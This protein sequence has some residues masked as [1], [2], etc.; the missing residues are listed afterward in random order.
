M[1]VVKR[2]II[3][4]LICICFLKTYWSYQQQGF[5]SYSEQTP[6]KISFTCHSQCLLLL[7][8][9]LHNDTVFI[10]GVH[11]NG[12]LVIAV[13]DQKNQLIPITQQ[14]IDDRSSYNIL[15]KGPQIGE[16]PAQAPIVL[17]VVWQVVANDAY[18]VLER[19]SLGDKFIAGFREFWEIGAFM[20]YSINLTK[21]PTVLWTSMNYYF[22]WFIIIAFLSILFFKK[23][24][25]IVVISIFSLWILYSI[26]MDIEFLSYTYD[27]YITWIAESDMS[28]KSY[29][30]IYANFPVFVNWS[31]D[32]VSKKWMKSYHFYTQQVWPFTPFIKYNL[33]P[34]QLLDMNSDTLIVWNSVVN[35]QT[36][37][38]YY[39]NNTKKFIYST[40]VSFP[41]GGNSFIYFK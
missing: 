27:N 17:V 11:W 25:A 29:K 12:Q 36:W 38:V 32:E 33:Y 31:R 20:P 41:Y 3:L 30:K 6:D 39:D 1:I 7:W 28:Q 18:I 13:M 14:N 5:D 21:A 8:P 35:E 2:L 34:L 26:R 24:R 10:D 15:L 23:W 22:Y 9:K 16:I 40:K 37:V 4:F 19:M